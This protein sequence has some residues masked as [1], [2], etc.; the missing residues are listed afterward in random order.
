MFGMCDT[1]VRSE[2]KVEVNYYKAA[3]LNKSSVLLHEIRDISMH[4]SNK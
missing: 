4:Y 3:D 1:G 2:E